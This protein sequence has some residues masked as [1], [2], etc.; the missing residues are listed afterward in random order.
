MPWLMQMGGCAVMIIGIALAVW[1]GFWL[2]VVLAAISLAVAGYRY[3]VRKGVINA[4]PG[5]PPE[6]ADGEQKVSITV[7]EGE[8]ER[9]E[10]DK[11][12][13]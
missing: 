10:S 3:L 5:V 8:Y 11:K 9:V 1:I 7:I 6:G 13:E 12:P 2:F 4:T